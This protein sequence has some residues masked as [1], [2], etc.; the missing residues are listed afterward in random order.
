MHGEHFYQKMHGKGKLHKMFQLVSVFVKSD[1]MAD[2][3][4][5]R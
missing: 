4:K 2:W 3:G 1:K 5:L